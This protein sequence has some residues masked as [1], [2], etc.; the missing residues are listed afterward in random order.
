MLPNKPKIALLAGS[1]LTV[2]GLF[3]TIAALGS[4]TS[5][6]L[7]SMV[8]LVGI[9]PLAYGLITVVLFDQGS[10]SGNRGTAPPKTD[11]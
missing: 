6:V 7:W 5:V 10:R 9:F 2:G 1:V 4:T 11:P 3:Q 8:A